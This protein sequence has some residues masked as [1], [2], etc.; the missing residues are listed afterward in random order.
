[1]R[2]REQSVARW[3][4]V[5]LLG[6]LCAFA[7]VDAA[8][9]HASKQ[10]DAGP[11]PAM[12]IPVDAMGYRPPGKLYLLARYTSSSLDFLDDKHLLFTF[13]QPRLLKREAGSSSGLDQVV[14]ADAIEL[15]EGKVVAEDHWILHD[16]ER[17]VWRLGGGRAL[18]RIGSRLH[19][20]GPDLEL[21]PIY[22]S[23]TRLRQVEVSPDGRLLLLESD[24]ER[25]TPEEHRRLA[26]HAELVGA[27]PPAEDVEI[28]MARLDQKKMLMGA[29]SDQAGDL[30]ATLHGYLIQERVK[31]TRWRVQFHPFE[32]PQQAPGELVAEVESSCAPSEKVLNEE[33]VLVLS[34]PPKRGDRFAAAYGLKGEKLWD[35]RW[36][37]NF[38]WPAFRVSEDGST[39][40]ISWLAVNRPVS[41]M[42][43]I[44]D[45][46]VQ[47]QV[48]SVLDT[49]TGALRIG[50][51]VSPIVSA[52]GNFALSADGSRLAVLNK[53]ALEIYELPPAPAPA[54][55]AQRAAQ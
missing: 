50:M 13:R 25:H 9:L 29:K 55:S 37:S 34:C 41:P 11:K 53:G 14:Q 30:P 44:A 8:W 6:L 16:R 23:P 33:T 35:G 7:C 17:Y 27:E 4:G 31:E 21:K 20:M 26:M 24:R 38:T 22:E 18:V 52:G 15:P 40:A 10:R 45:E 5:G 32:S 51:V 28:R 1:V 42:D 3:P 46:E 39:V 47:S 2:R 43:P 19:E 48:L 12:R 49:R 36:Q 54:A